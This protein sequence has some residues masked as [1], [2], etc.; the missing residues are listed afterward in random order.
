MCDQYT[1]VGNVRRD[2]RKIVTG[3]RNNGLLPGFDSFQLVRGEIICSNDDIKILEMFPNF[4]SEDDCVLTVVMLH[5]SKKK[6]E[7]VRT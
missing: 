5:K 7:K 3:M 2:V 4:G 6:K 1:S